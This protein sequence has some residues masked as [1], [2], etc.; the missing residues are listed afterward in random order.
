MPGSKKEGFMKKV[1]VLISGCGFLDGAEIRESV[2]TLLALD[3][4]SYRA[5]KEIQ[6]V[7]MAPNS[8]QHHVI[9][10]LTGQE[11]AEVRNILVE[12]ARIGRGKVSDLSTVDPMELD[13]LILPGGY[14]V[15]KNLSNFAFRGAQ[16]EVIPEVAEFILKVHQ[17]RKP[18]GAICISPAILALLLGRKG[19]NLTLGDDP[20]TISQVEKTGA[21]HHQKAANEIYH[22]K[23]LNV[24]STPA[25]MYGDAP[26]HEIAVGIERLVTAILDQL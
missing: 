24:V 3:K 19:I 5:Q 4:L 8:Q 2:L 7:I 14:G 15:A 23:A 12:S 6:V 17:N 10:H 1:G 11:T 18:L 21:K 26:L 9:N 13:A 20:E 22:D 16:A 25:Y